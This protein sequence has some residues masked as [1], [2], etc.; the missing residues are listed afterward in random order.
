MIPACDGQTVRRS[1]GQTE[2]I[3]AKS[4][5][6]IA[7]YADA[8]STRLCLTA[9]TE[10]ELQILESIYYRSGWLRI[11]EMR[12]HHPASPAHPHPHHHQQLQHVDLLANATPERRLQLG[13][14]ELPARDDN[15]PSSRYR[16]C[17]S[18]KERIVC[19]IFTVS[20]LLNATII[21]V[22]WWR[23]KSGCPAAQPDCPGGHVS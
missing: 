10:T 19:I 17:V 18:S 15:Q 14:R 21:A 3:I 11:V 4:A 20:L 12:R 8:L 23:W 9:V 22:V 5:L 13:S 1:D 16:R 2:C 7:S 6:C